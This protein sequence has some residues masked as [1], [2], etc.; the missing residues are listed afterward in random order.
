VPR[1]ESGHGSAHITKPPLASILI[2]SLMGSTMFTIAAL[3]LAVDL[4][5]N[6]SLAREWY[7]A[8]PSL[9]LVTHFFFFVKAVM[10]PM[11]LLKAGWV[12]IP[13][14]ARRRPGCIFGCVPLFVMPLTLYLTARA[15]TL[16]AAIGAEDAEAVDDELHAITRLHLL[17]CA[18]LPLMPASALAEYVS[19]SSSS[20]RAARAGARVAAAKLD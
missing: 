12:S 7:R 5:G 14:V 3:D 1:P 11:M 9:P 19:I 8:Q 10:L 16:A 17:K 15:A 2:P 18:L 13:G 6:D 4:S 20:A